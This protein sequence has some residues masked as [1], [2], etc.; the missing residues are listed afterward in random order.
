METHQPNCEKS[1]EKVEEVSLA[2]LLEIEPILTGGSVPGQ[3]LEV[4]KFLQRELP[5]RSLVE[6]R[7]K[8]L[9][10]AYD[11]LTHNY[12]SMRYKL[13]ALLAAMPVYCMPIEKP[14]TA[15][16]SS[17][18]VRSRSRRPIQQSEA[19]VKDYF[20]RLGG[21]VVSLDEVALNTGVPKATVHMLLHRL[22][23]K[24]VNKLSRGN[25]TNM[26]STNGQSHA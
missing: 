7:L 15:P 25:Y 12:I 6:A 23:G 21:R 11:D 13:E 2:S 8:E 20:G 1:L 24:Y 4:N 9:E 26:S 5:P 19:L 22:N 17:Q 18:V 10:Q 16:E 14:V 3:L